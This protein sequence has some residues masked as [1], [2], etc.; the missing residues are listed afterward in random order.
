VT[1]EQFKREF[2]KYQPGFV[3]AASDMLHDR[4]EAQDVVMDTAEKLLTRLERYDPAVATFRTWFTASVKNEALIRLRS[5]RAEATRVERSR[6][7]GAG[8]WITRSVDNTLLEKGAVI[9]D[10]KKALAT[11]SPDD[12]KTLQ[13][14]L[15]D[16]VEVD[17]SLK[18]AFGQIV[19]RGAKARGR[20]PRWFMNEV[21]G[22][23]ER[24]R[25]LLASYSVA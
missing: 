17:A 10:V 23:V 14:V 20:D 15:G 11:F 18:S 3:K 12:R 1:R 7:V 19:V 5:K 22:L 6:R 16:G 25:G 21:L 4:E 8:I 24:L 9:L 2:L 13:E